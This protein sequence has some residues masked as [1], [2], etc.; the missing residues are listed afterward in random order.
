MKP[1]AWIVLGV[2]YTVWPMDLI[3]D[4]PGIGWV[5][6]AVIDLFCAV[7][8]ARGRKGNV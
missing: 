7:M 3:P 6:D 5:D 1:I 8:M 2:V 4:V